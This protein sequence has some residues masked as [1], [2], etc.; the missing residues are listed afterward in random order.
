MPHWPLNL[1]RDLR[2]TLN[3]GS[4]S[5][6]ARVGVAQITLILPSRN[7]FSM[8]SFCFCKRPAWWKAMLLLKQS[9]S[10]LHCFV[11]V[12]DTSRILSFRIILLVFNF[13]AI[14]K[15]HF[16]ALALDETKTIACFFTWLFLELILLLEALYFRIWGFLL[17][18]LVWMWVVF[19]MFVLVVCFD[20]GNVS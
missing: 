3:T 11:G 7:S 5:P 1:F 8:I 2:I 4:E 13:L 17:R 19:E 10:F 18:L 20:K 15:A 14:S 12:G 16:W 9:E 6:A